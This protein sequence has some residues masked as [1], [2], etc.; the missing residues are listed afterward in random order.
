MHTFVLIDRHHGPVLAMA[1]A[2]LKK[3]A[4][5]EPAHVAPFEKILV[6]SGKPTGQGLDSFR[7]WLIES[8][9]FLAEF[10][11]ITF[12]CKVPGKDTVAESWLFGPGRPPTREA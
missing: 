6:F 1:T 2:Q 9:G 10:W 8:A 12:R 4:T 7:A 11:N 5:G 3:T